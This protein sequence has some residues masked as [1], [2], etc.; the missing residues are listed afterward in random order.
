MSLYGV[1]V[2]IGINS[3]NSSTVFITVIYKNKEKELIKLINKIIGL[4]VSIL[5]L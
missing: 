2:F 4:S 3:L 5:N 1:L